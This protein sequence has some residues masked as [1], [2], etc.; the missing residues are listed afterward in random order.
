MKR[1][2]IEA[3]N[4]KQLEQRIE[5]LEAEVRA[6]KELYKKLLPADHGNCDDKDKDKDNEDEADGSWYT[7]HGHGD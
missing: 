7:N 6:L 1:L 5:S 2:I 3:M 4:V